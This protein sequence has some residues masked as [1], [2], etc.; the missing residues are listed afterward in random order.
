MCCVG[1]CPCGT[2][3]HTCIHTPISSSDRVCSRIDLRVPDVACVLFLTECAQYV[4]ARRAAVGGRRSA[5]MLS[6]SVGRFH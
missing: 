5:H 2:A 3:Q 4:A 1:V 6:R